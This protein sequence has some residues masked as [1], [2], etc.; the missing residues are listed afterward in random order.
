MSWLLAT[1]YILAVSAFI[2]AG[3]RGADPR[4]RGLIGGRYGREGGPADFAGRSGSL[5]IAA[6]LLERLRS[7]AERARS[8]AQVPDL[9]DLLAVSVTAGLSPRIAL[10]RAP[11]VVGGG[12][13]EALTAVRTDVSLGAPWHTA[14]ETAGREGGIEELR[15]LAVTLH[16]A[17]RLGS[18][19]AN[20]LRDLAVEVRGEWRARRE[21]RARRAPIQMLFPLVFLILPAFVLAAVVPALLVATR[22]IV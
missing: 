2:V 9:L 10:E 12:L 5:P 8:A 21:E 19:V 15:R 1:A 20:R 7:K 11:D 14:L 17:E 13:G 16:R 6:A 3:A 18:P 22:D 4:I